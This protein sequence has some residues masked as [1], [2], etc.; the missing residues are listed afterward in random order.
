MIE[1][2][3]EFVVKEEA[4]G[5]FELAYGPGGAWSK[6][7][8]R[9][10]G[11]RGT[12]LLRDTQNPRRYMAIELWDT[13]A[14]REQILVERQSEYSD[15]DAALAGW[16]ETKTEAGIFTVLAE[17][18]VRPRGRARRSSVGQGRRR[19]RLPD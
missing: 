2:I 11:F 9:C 12:T 16:T 10:A 18:T 14:Q 6:L 3:W 1:I 7:F 5:Q 8:A 4:R 15:L 17:A 13:V 19:G